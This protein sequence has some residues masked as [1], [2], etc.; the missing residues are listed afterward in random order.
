MKKLLENWDKFVTEQEATPQAA[1]QTQE[2]QAAA[3]TQEP[4]AAVGSWPSSPPKT[5]KS[6]ATSDLDANTMLGAWKALAAKNPPK[7]PK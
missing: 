1:A 2:Q 3:Q 7:N 4:Q 6:T 5:I